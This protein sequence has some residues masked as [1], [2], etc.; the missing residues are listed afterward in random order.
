MIASSSSLSF[1]VHHQN[2]FLPKFIK[3]YDFFIGICMYSG[4]D[5]EC[6]TAIIFKTDCVD[7]ELS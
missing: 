7:I 3:L 5:A 1:H 6:K 4:K 2:F